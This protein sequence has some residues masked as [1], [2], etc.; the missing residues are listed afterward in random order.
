[1]FSVVCGAIITF[2]W[3]ENAL[4][5]LGTWMTT[6]KESWRL[7]SSQVAAKPACDGGV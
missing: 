2:G 7:Y 4:A 6:K 5:L 3:W 1:M